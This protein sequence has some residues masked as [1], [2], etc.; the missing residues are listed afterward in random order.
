MFHIDQ[1]RLSGGIGARSALIGTV[2][3]RT[4]GS[5]AVGVAGDRDMRP[6]ILPT[7]ACASDRF[8]HDAT[9]G[10]VRNDRFRIAAR[11]SDLLYLLP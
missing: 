8:F 1:V 9:C 7:R 11:L 4:Y 6:G 2:D 3:S 5:G 10:D